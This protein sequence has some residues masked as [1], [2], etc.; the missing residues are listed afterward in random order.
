MIK[1]NDEV[2][3][4]LT[5]TELREW[6]GSAAY[7]K[8]KNIYEDQKVLEFDIDEDDE[9]QYI[10]AVVKGSGRNRYEVEVEYDF[11]DETLEAT[12]EC[13]AYENGGGMC[14]HCVAVILEYMD[15]IK[16]CRKNPEKF[17]RGM[18]YGEWCN[19]T[20][21]QN[22]HFSNNETFNND[23]YDKFVDTL[24]EVIQ[25]EALPDDLIQ[26]RQQ[27]EK[28]QAKE[29]EKKKGMPQKAA[30]KKKPAL[31]TT[32]LM[33]QLLAKQVEKRT[34]PMLE[35]EITGKVKLEPHLKIQNSEISLTFK[36]GITQMYVL[37]NIREFCL[38][39]QEHK[40]YTYGQKLRFTHYLES[41]CEEDR[42]LV[43]FVVNAQRQ[44]DNAR[45]IRSYYGY[46]GSPQ[47]ELFLTSYQL[48]EFILAM[49][50]KPFLGAINYKDDKWWQLTDE[51]L[52]RELTIK[53]EA[54][55]IWL[56]IKSFFG[57]IGRTQNIYFYNNKV[58]LSPINN[59]SELEDFIQCMSQLEDRRAYIEKQD[60]P[61]FCRE[62]LPMLEANYQCK[63]KDFVPSS[64]GVVPA[65]FEVYL[66]APQS[67]WV[68]CKLEAIYEGK[69]YNVF[70][71]EEDKNFRDQ[72]S[73]TAIEQLVMAYATSYDNKENLAV[74]SDEEKIY[75]FLSNG[76]EKLRG[77]AEVYV[78][79]KL[80]RL[81]IKPAGK[82]SVSVSIEGTTLKL[83]MLS[84]GMTNE[85]FVDLL[86]K[87]KQKRK[88]YRLKDGSFINI[89]GEDIEILAEMSQSLN[90]SDK[91]L[92]NGTVEVPKYRALYLNGQLKE[93]PSIKTVKNKAFKELVRNMKTVED[94]DFEVPESLDNILREYQKR[95][96]LWMKTLKHNGFG[97][98]LADD[99]GLGKTLQVISFLLSEQ[100]EAGEEAN[101]K[102]LIVCPASLVFNWKTEIEKFAPELSVKMA[103]GTAKQRE[104]IISHL[105]DKDIVVTS[106]DLLKR[107]IAF[108]EN[109][110][111]GYEVID[112][113]QYIKN[114]NTQAAK[115][116]K[117]IQAGF[118]LALTG[119]PI[120]NRLS[121]LWSIFDYLMPGFLYPYT[122]FK[123]QLEIPITQNKDE[124]ATLRLQKMVQPFVLRRLKKEVLTDLPDKLEENKYATL[125]GEQQKLYDAHVKKLK[126]MLEKETEESFKKAKI[127]VLS[128]LTR[129]RQICCEPSLIYE[130]YKSGSSKMEMCM[131]LVENAISSGHKILL[132]SQFTSMLDQIA[133]RFKKEG[134]SYFLLTGATSKEKRMEMVEKFNT[135][136]TSV[137]CI[138]LKAGGT[139]LNLTA[140]DIVIHFDP[141]W[142]VA[143]QNQA[144]DRA[145]RIGQE[146]VVTVYKLIAKGTIEEKIVNIQELKKE[147]AD[148]ILSGEGMNTGS[149]TKEDLLEL[150]EE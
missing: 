5:K 123:E 4:V 1:K 105:E 21:L 38:N 35:E 103:V 25:G 66:D 65:E 69:R 37:K 43:K 2:A 7:N 145:H 101:L 68:T 8:G 17:G 104:E 130:D 40:L 76:I 29:T 55:G 94:N 149:F 112:E 118:K 87:Y 91:E 83:S 52:P 39:L 32:P 53:G 42:A 124:A 98:I 127:Q 54:E 24:W 81:V 72:V 10:N 136:D 148:Q 100:Q 79:D 144:T 106:Y 85:E 137:F 93:H 108:Y 150:L 90:L 129:L 41:F 119:T 48:E 88:F 31:P 75:E 9:K 107:D 56:E 15:Y 63:K 121:E 30:E 147:L 34:L 77:K 67:N 45:Q 131:E 59:Q 117:D 16:T 132:F 70:E 14:K 71:H 82:V 134:I 115:A 12:C 84:D 146:N 23:E 26:L 139:G 128:E 99:M 141:W 133:A 19:I 143:V 62:L 73:E 125:E 47:R 102:T 20:G 44:S 46:Y 95:G 114:H 80:K 61:A 113:G 138:S 51:K 122:R 6:A 64:Y 135:D 140:A 110:A 36:I 96:F 111:F 97:G 74:M 78:S 58:Y 28:R 92:K 49:G 89:E 18:S 50:E 57:V 60:V 126:M 109:I 116:V 120:E 22:E 11:M 33:K 13:P 142:N 27:L 86:S 3:K